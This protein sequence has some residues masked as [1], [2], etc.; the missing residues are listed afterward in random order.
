MESDLELIERFCATGSRAS[1]ESLVSRHGPMIHRLGMRVLHD[2]HA[3]DDVVQLTLIQLLQHPTSAYPQV[4]GWL[5]RVAIN[6]ARNLRRSRESQARREEAKVRAMVAI[7]WD[8]IADNELKEE[9][10]T[11]LDRLPDPLREAIIL[12]YLEGRSHEETARLSGC[13]EEAVRKRSQRGLR[14]L[15][16]ILA[17]RGVLCGLGTLAAFFA[18]ESAATAATA[19]ATLAS[20]GWDSIAWPGTNDPVSPDPSRFTTSPDGRGAGGNLNPFAARLRPM[21]KVVLPMTG[22]LIGMLG[23]FWVAHHVVGASHEQASNRPT[24]KSASAL[25]DMTDRSRFVALPMGPAANASSSRPIFRPVGGNGDTLILPVWGDIAAGGIPFHVIDPRQGTARNAI[26]LHSTIGDYR[27]RRPALSSLPC[28]FP[29]VAIHLLGGVSAGGYPRSSKRTVT[30]I[31]RLRYHDGGVEEIPLRN[32][33]HFVDYSQKVDVP[34]S[35]PAMA[36][37]NGFQIRRLSIRPRRLATIEQIEFFKGNDLTV[38]VVLAVTIETTEESR[39]RGPDQARALEQTQVRADP[40]SG[41]EV[42]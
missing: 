25:V 30:L 40:R 34:G 16:E 37:A 6:T 31:V 23:W 29:A 20:L 3:A 36:L 8:D 14:R 19:T 9:I 15:R 11:A 28:G 4:A 41:A 35:K 18:T 7:P 39:G 32:G 2:R 1:F 5:H 26:V 17:E 27:D 13:S 42:R 21:V 24:S 22:L 38:P 12:H 33:V 10:D